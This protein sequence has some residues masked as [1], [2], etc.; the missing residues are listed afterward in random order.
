MAETKKKRPRTTKAKKKNAPKT[1]AERDAILAFL[2]EEIVAPNNTTAD[3][4]FNN[5]KDLDDEINAI[6]KKKKIKRDRVG[7]P[8]AM[9]EPTL[10]KLKVAYLINCTDEEACGFAGIGTT[11]L[12]D[13]QKKHPEF[14]ELKKKWRDTH[15]MAARLNVFRSVVKDANMGDSWLTLRTQRKDEYSEKHIVT[16]KN[17]V[18]IEELEKISQGDYEKL[19]EEKQTP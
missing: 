12:Y 5:P 4:D 8:T 11:T 6:V 18:S 3:I 2:T 9:T 13:F 17:V 10:R 15:V 16:D 19:P 1:P 7:R 14:T